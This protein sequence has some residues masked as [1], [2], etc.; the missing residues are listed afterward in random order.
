MSAAA[1]V[2]SRRQEVRFNKLPELRHGG[3]NGAARA[4]YDVFIVRCDVWINNRLRGTLR[5]GEF[6]GH[7]IS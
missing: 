2:R 6:F 4:A 1:E 3:E 5:T 7:G